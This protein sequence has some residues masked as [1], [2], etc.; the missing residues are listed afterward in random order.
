VVDEAH[1]LFS[2]PYSAQFLAS[3]YKRARKYGGVCTSI[4]Q[5]ISDLLESPLA[6]KMLANSDY[7]LMLNQA[8]QD[9]TKLAEILNISPTQLSFVT[10]ANAGQGLLFAGNS[11]VP[12]VD[13][14]PQDTQLY[15]M[16]T[17]KLDEVI[18]YDKENNQG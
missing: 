12:F 8:P 16:M 14:F 10:N 2:N 3:L 5:N 18:S 9:R 4:T 1:L 13:K 6:S 11:I 17:T 15:R 7:I